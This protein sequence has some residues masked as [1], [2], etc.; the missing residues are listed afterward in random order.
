MGVQLEL[1]EAVERARDAAAG[2]DPAPTE[3][4]LGLA[5]VADLNRCLNRPFLFPPVDFLLSLQP[6][7]QLCCLGEGS[8]VGWRRGDRPQS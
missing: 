5:A 1:E 6:S 4:G 2:Q 7:P 8:G 3:R